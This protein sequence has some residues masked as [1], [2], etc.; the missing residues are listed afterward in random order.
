MKRMVKWAIGNSPA[1]NTL[2]IASLIVGAASLVMMR[3]EVFPEFQLEI[4]LV[5]VAYPGATAEEVEEAICEKIE[6][7]ISEVDGI[8]KITSAAQESVGYAILELNADV[9]DVQKVL[10]DIRSAIDQIT[11]FPPLAEDPDVRQ[12]VFRAPSIYIGLLGPEESD[13]P[14][15]EQRK[16]LRNLAEEIRDDLL[17]QPPS[18]P[19]T[20]VRRIFKDFIAPPGRPA[21]TDADI[22]AAREYEI[23]VEISEDALRRHGLSLTQ[24]AQII[25]TQNGESPGGK[26][27]SDSQEIL[28]RAKSKQNDGKGIKRIKVLTRKNGDV[29]TVEDLGAVIDGFAETTSKH[30]IDGRPGMVISVNKTSNE[31]LFTVVNAARE[32]IENRSLPEGYEIKVWGD[33]SIDVRDRLDML[34][35]NGLQGLILVFVVLLL[36]LDMRLAF[37]VALGIPVSILGA[38]FVLLYFGATLNM[39]TMFAFLMAMGIVVDDAI[40]IGENIYTKRQEG[41]GFI[42]AAIEGTVEV[43]PSVTAS[44]MT[45]VIAFMPL[46]FVSGVMGKFIAVMPLAIIAMLLISLFESVFILPCHLGHKDNLFLKII[47][48][49]LYALAP[50][51]F[52]TNWLNKKAS[53]GMEWTIHKIYTPFNRWCINNKLVVCTAAFGLLVVSM[54]AISS[55]IVPYEVF[56]K[57][58]S[59]SV[60]A[61][62]VFPEGTMQEYAEDATVKLKHAAERVREKLIA[63]GHP[64]AIESIY[65]RIGEVGSN[66]QG[67]TGITSG[68]HVGTVE[69]KLAPVDS[70]SITSTQITTMWRDEIGEIAGT[71]VLKFGSRSMGPGGSAIQFKLLARSRD[72][73]FL[74]NA[75][76]DAKQYLGKQVGV[77]DIE[78][79]H[80]PGKTEQ[81]FEL[82]EKGHALGLNEDDLGSA[83][84]AAYFGAEVMRLQRG[85]HEVKLM[86]RY[87]RDHRYSINSLEEVRVKDDNGNEHPLYEISNHYFQKKNA[88]INRLN[89]MRSIT[90][91]ADVDQTKGANAFE[92]VT[93]MKN[94]FIPSLI[95]KYRDENNV[96]MFVD[97]EGEQQQNSESMAS[98]M[99]GFIIA[100]LA[101]YVL[102]TLEFRSYLQPLLILAI[103]PFGMVGAVL[104]HWIL[105]LSLTMFTMFG[106]VALTGVIVNDSIV[107]VDFINKKLATGL[108]IKEALVEAGARRFRPIMLTTITTVAGLSPILF[109]KSFQAQVVI[110]MAATIVFGLATGTF[111]IL[112]FVPVFYHLYYNIAARFV[113]DDDD[114]LKEI[115]ENAILRNGET[116][117]SSFEIQ[118]QDFMDVDLPQQ[119]PE[120][121][122][123]GVGSNGE[124]DNGDDQ[125]IETKHPG[126]TIAAK[127]GSANG[128]GHTPGGQKS[129]ADADSSETEK[130]PTSVSRDYPDVGPALS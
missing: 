116:T 82:N 90:I 13:L 75:A 28:L 66:L 44:V 74:V 10:N 12:I 67:P 19:K 41:M 24:V 9:K 6:S 98:M 99:F 33:M 94:E 38:G 32:Y 48:I 31:D 11:T 113:E 118:D 68:S 83:I 3:R 47:G 114:S 130:E 76:E 79:D 29:V 128:N 106:L 115:E 86:V 1:M 105:G 93:R 58:D 7:R 123:T 95:K 91:T 49:C 59:N 107:L 102:L 110:P 21:I 23:N 36:F 22:I 37:W 121:V 84:R 92:I 97:W 55:R 122:L 117:Q 70:R 60:D 4:V 109:E 129:N 45:T 50:L 73:D 25:R 53:G 16:Q 54:G 120:P 39:L 80:R 96:S 34:T 62:V 46:M 26:L 81:I 71:D 2:L 64:K 111:L 51:L 72:A 35:R 69:L 57:L 18:E 126:E 40:V 52:V 101:I 87:P 5:T 8:K 63:D 15:L 85:E 100:M 42:K 30:V 14:Q 88:R 112:I 89:Q 65:Q 77:V 108:P 43:I 61:T 124:H 104:G 125:H 119:E 20:F 56:P 27:Q 17:Q 78:D 127:K 103:I